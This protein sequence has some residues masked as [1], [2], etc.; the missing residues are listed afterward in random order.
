VT[1]ERWPGT[2]V[3]RIAEPAGCGLLGA[4]TRV[5]GVV[6]P[7]STLGRQGSHRD[8][9]MPSQGVMLT[10]P[11]GFREIDRRTEFR[12]ALNVVYDRHWW[13]LS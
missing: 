5:P 1:P 9:R 7:L 10:N 3:R 11:G 6:G 13:W 12:L 2:T 4:R 8:C